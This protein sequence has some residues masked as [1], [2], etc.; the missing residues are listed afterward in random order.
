MN[1]LMSTNPPMVAIFMTSAGPND[2]LMLPPKVL[3]IQHM[4]VGDKD[5]QS[6]G[7]TLPT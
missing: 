7:I 6:I 1:L 3:G 4:T 5:I 2:L